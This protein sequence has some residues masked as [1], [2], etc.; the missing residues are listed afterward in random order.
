LFTLLLDC[1]NAEVVWAVVIASQEVAILCAETRVVGLAAGVD[2]ALDCCLA[3]IKNTGCCVSIACLRGSAIASYFCAA[4]LDEVVEV[5]AEEVA[6]W[7]AAKEANETRRRLV[8][9]IL[10]KGW[11]SLY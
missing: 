4:Q 6:V 10:F 1:K 7:A 5:L 9:C 2:L 8:S 11:M 3:G